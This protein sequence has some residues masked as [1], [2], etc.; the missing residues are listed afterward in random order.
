[1]NRPSLSV[2]FAIALLLL[3]GAGS[4]NAG[5]PETSFVEVHLT[6]MGMH[7][8]GCEQTIESTFMKMPGVDSVKADYT[9]KDVYVK[10]DTTKTSYSRLEDLISELGFDTLPEEGL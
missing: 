7:C 9:T 10:V 8:D 4:K 1:M 3:A 2:F 6:A 5:T